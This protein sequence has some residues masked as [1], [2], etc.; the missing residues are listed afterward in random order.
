MHKTMI[1]FLKKLVVSFL[2]CTVAAHAADC[3]DGSVR[4]TA[5]R[6]EI[7]LEKQGWRTL[8]ADKAA[9]GS[10]LAARQM[11]PELL[12]NFL[13]VVGTPVVNGDSLTVPATILNRSCT[14]VLKKAQQTPAGWAAEK[15]DCKPR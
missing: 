8:V 6:T 9:V 5:G 12:G 10:E 13:T 1:Y 2:F 11:I 7:C 15:I 4:T 14:V 3:V